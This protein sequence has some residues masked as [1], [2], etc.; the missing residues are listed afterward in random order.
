MV[1]RITNGHHPIA[2]QCSQRR[3]LGPFSTNPENGPS[4]LP[5]HK[6]QVT[7]ARYLLHAVTASTRSAANV[8]DIVHFSAVLSAE[9]NPVREDNSRE[10]RS[11]GP[12]KSIE[13][14][15]H[16]RSEMEHGPGKKQCY[17]YAR[18]RYKSYGKNDLYD[19]H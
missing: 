13:A 8:E 11:E 1:V 10:R 5:D 12:K 4:S 16:G 6:P 9:E 17:Q 18:G 2:A 19:Y 14:N 15:Q 7:G 3:G